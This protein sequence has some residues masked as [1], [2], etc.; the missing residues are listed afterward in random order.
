MG[1][2]NEAGGLETRTLSAGPVVGPARLLALKRAAKT[3]VQAHAVLQMLRAVRAGPPLVGGAARRRLP[4]V[5]PPHAAT[6]AVTPRRKATPS[7]LRP[8]ETVGPA[9]AAGVAQPVAQLPVLL[10]G[11][12]AR[13]PPTP[14]TLAPRKTPPPGHPRCARPLWGPHR[15]RQR[16]RRVP[17]K[18]GRQRDQV[19][20]PLE[21]KGHRPYA[22][23]AV[24]PGVTARRPPR[25]RRV[26]QLITA[27]TVTPLPRPT[28]GLR[29]VARRAVETGPGGPVSTHGPVAT[30]K[31]SKAAGTPGR[32]RA[33]MPGQMTRDRRVNSCGWRAGRSQP[34]A[35]SPGDGP[36]IGSANVF[37]TM[38]HHSESVSNSR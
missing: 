22:T 19:V 1:Q 2:S 34:R 31:P 18:P 23:L 30:G 25:I 7:A 27:R 9:Q 26:L 10:V 37:K 3:P 11:P 17:L 33:P 35:P 29:A 5:G 14:A 20:V 6:R 15:L 32:S 21:A 28:A 4:H 36:Q 13:K 8:D 24:E 12:R 16:P 38:P